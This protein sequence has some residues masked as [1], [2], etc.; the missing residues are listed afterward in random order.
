[1]ATAQGQSLDQRSGL[2]DVLVALGLPVLVAAPPGGDDQLVQR[3]AFGRGDAHRNAR[4]VQQNAARRGVDQVIEKAQ[5]H[6]GGPAKGRH[7]RR[8]ALMVFARPVRGQELHLHVAR[9]V[10]GGKPPVH[11]VRHLVKGLLHRPQNVEDRRQAVIHQQRDRMEL[12]HVDVGR[13]QRLHRQQH[14][15]QPGV[16][17]EGDRSDQ[18]AA[19]PK[20]SRPR[21]RLHHIPHQRIGSWQSSGPQRVHHPPPVP[22]TGLDLVETFN[23]PGDRLLARGAN[24]GDGFGPG[25]PV[26]TVVVPIMLT[27]PFPFGKG[28]VFRIQLIKRGV[29]TPLL[30][31]REHGLKRQADRIEHRGMGD[32]CW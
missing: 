12:R 22:E 16:G 21:Q 25:L 28:S 18:H 4:L 10:F 7:D 24:I 1:M 2:M 27:V 19:Q 14:A 23:P 9:P 20:G 26:V 6:G 8:F 11:R 31:L 15:D 3:V 32:L 30:D 29:E 17:L 5:R 13:R